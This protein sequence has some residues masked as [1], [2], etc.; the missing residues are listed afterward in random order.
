MSQVWMDPPYSDTL[1]HFLRDKN[2][3]AGDLSGRHEIRRRNRCKPYQY[4]ID[5]IREISNVFIPTV[6]FFRGHIKSILNNN[7]VDIAEKDNQLGI[8]LYACHPIVA[9]N[10]YIILTNSSQIRCI[11]GNLFTAEKGQNE[12]KLVLK[13]A[14]S[15]LSD[16]RTEWAYDGKTIKHLSTDTCLTALTRDTVGLKNCTGFLDQSW[17]WERVD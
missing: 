1:Q 2:Y 3:T 9:P 15:E 10:Q 8:I 16:N 4:F 6:V 7:C 17:E 12:V 11:K 14:L 5:K 13:Q